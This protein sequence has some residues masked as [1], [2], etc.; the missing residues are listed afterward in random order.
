MITTIIH[1]YLMFLSSFPSDYLNINFG[2][3][4]CKHGLIQVLQVFRN[5]I[6]SRKRD[7][8]TLQKC[9]LS[10]NY[11]HRMASP[12]P[13]FL[14]FIQYSLDSCRTPTKTLAPLTPSLPVIPTDPFFYLVDLANKTK[15][16]KHIKLLRGS[17]FLP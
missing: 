13:F 16:K 17:T 7:L 6:I 15:Q 14:K 8:F 12:S 5:Y 9:F 4:F 1:R 11:P 3:M 10:L 2:K